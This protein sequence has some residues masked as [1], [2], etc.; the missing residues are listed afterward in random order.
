M[1]MRGD[2]EWHYRKQEEE[3]C[4]LVVGRGEDADPHFNVVLLTVG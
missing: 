3:V 4:K 2:R 1:E